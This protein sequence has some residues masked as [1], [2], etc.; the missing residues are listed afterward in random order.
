M[1]PKI[2][3]VKIKGLKKLSVVRT[4]IWVELPIM[5]LYLALDS[6]ILRKKEKW[7]SIVGLKLEEQQKK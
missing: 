1:L 6:C 4:G 2:G 5:Q 3:H 7:S